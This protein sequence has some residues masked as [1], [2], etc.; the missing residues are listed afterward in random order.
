M[1]EPTSNPLIDAIDALWPGHGGQARAAEHFKIT[2][3]SIRR[4]I[5]GEREIPAWMA[6]ELA[7]LRQQFPNG[8]KTQDPRA[9]LKILHDQMVA[10]GW[11]ANQSAAG[12]LGA[13][14]ALARKHL[15]QD[16]ISSLLQPDDH[17]R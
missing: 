3:R 14:S 12:I 15:S 13:A 7:D 2:D 4:Y 17:D 11:P 8:I 16:M 10:S 9:T 5:S 1:T 6:N